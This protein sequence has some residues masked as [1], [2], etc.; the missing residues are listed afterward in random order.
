MAASPIAP[1]G[2]NTPL[3]EN[4]EQTSREDV[5]QSTGDADVH[6]NG[7]PTLIANENHK[8]AGQ[9]VTSQENVST[10]NDNKGGDDNPAEA[11]SGTADTAGSTGGDAA[12]GE[13]QI[14]PN[15]VYIGGLPEHT[16]KE[17][18]ESCFGKIGNIV[19]VELKVGYGFVEFDNREAAEES[20]AKYHEGYFMGNKIRVELSRGGGRTAKYS[21]DPGACFKCGQVGHWARECPN[22]AI[23]ARPGLYPADASL[24]DRIHPHRGEYVPPPPRDYPLYR[25]DYARYPPARDPRYAYDYPLPPPRRPLSPSRDYY[26]PPPPPRSA[27]DL[28][29]YRVRG[30]P[31]PPPRYD[32]RPGG[33]YPPE[34]DALP[35]PGYPPRA[36]GLP[37]PPR[38]YYDRYDRRPP[39][40]DRYAPYP[41]PVA[42]ARTPPGAPPPRTREDYDRAPA[43]DYVPPTAEY[44]RGRG[45]PPPP[46]TRYS[47]YPSRTGTTET[48]RYSRR[49]SQSPPPRTSSGTYES[50]YPPTPSSQYN[51]YSSTA[52]APPSRG[53][54][55]APRE[56]PTPA[57]SRDDFSSRRV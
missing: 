53:G 16:R 30:P 9:E 55:S 26:P 3:Q 29:D 4:W 23:N 45:T 13:K 22:N 18:L 19:N 8:T 6:N 28:D 56:Y 36:Y 31:P 54:S 48:P 27:R 1:S 40:V 15:K 7:A 11:A 51:G 17:D 46:S 49:R 10:S 47:E 41:P 38:D 2:D 14:K 42:R 25:D 35:P 12:R 50:G 39:P 43:R 33:Y 34:G 32:S 57:R 24:I 44:T 52:A 20:V 37:P 21:G 5:A